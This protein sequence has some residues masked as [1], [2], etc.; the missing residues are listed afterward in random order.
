M[1]KTA[2]IAVLLAMLSSCMPE[3]A[4]ESCKFPAAAQQQ[5]VASEDGT[6]S[7]TCKVEHPE[8]P[9]GYCVSYM[10]ADPFCSS[11]CASDSDCQDGGSCIEFALEC[12][13]A[14]GCLHLCIKDSLLK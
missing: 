4:Y 6:L 2:A 3:D 14:A 10:G 5:C 1:L 11:R 12:E 13:S 8:C 7:N 9:D